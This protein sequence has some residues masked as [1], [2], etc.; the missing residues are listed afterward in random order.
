MSDSQLPTPP[1]HPYAAPQRRPGRVLAITAMALGLAALVTSAVAP[2]T[3]GAFAVVGACVGGVAVVL[4]VIA[5]VLRQRTAV[6]VV[7]LAAGALAIVVALVLGMVSIG[8]MFAGAAAE[9]RADTAEVAP[10]PGDEATPEAASVTWPRNMATGGVVFT[11]KDAAVFESDALADSAVPEPRTAAELG[12]PA[13]IQVYLDYRC[14]Y[15]ALFEEANGATLTEVL[16]Q[17]AAA[18]EMHP[19]TFLDRASEGSYYSSRTAGALACI[20]DAQPGAAWDA[21]TALADPALQPTEGEPGHDNAA[22]VA[23]IEQKTGPL[24]AAA[25]SCIADETFVPLVQALNDWTFTNPVPGAVDPELG[26]TGT[27]L[28]VVNGVPYP[29]DP[30]DADSFRAFLIQQGVALS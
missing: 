22:I 2:V 10:E 16:T 18:V 13:L 26:V 29:G 24:S 25:S 28:V 23:A 5:L 19:L 20:A 14:P 17:E 8:A 6:A 15:C 9:G 21:N 4:G 11:G 1:P 12:A 27:P 3:F 7:G 30:T